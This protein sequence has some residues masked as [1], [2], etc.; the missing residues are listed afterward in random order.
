M[1]IGEY[2]LN[3]SVAPGHAGSGISATSLFEPLRESAEPHSA[4]ALRNPL[5]VIQDGK[6]HAA[7]AFLDAYFDAA[8]ARMAYHVRKCFACDLVAELLN[9]TR[10]RVHQIRVSEPALN[11]GIAEAAQFVAQRL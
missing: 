8:C 9:R 2:N 1:I 10:Q 4:R 11:A 5:A 6:P 7:A 3:L